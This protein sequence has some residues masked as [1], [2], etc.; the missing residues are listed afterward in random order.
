MPD[1]IETL[2]YLG[3]FLGAA[4]E[5]EVSYV[6]I[7]QA[8]RQ[9]YLY[10]PYVIA[11]VFLGTVASD[12]GYFFL[13]RWQGKACLRRFPRLRGRMEQMDRLLKRR[14][15]LLL[16]SYRFMYGFRT[17]LPVLFGV[18]AIPASRF[19]AFS[20]LSITLWVSFFGLGGYFFA[21]WL[22]NILEKPSELSLW[23][24]SIPIAAGILAAIWLYY[25]RRAPASA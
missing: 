10:W 12:W 17:I 22:L 11:A 23:T 19:L 25:R 21:A 4:L 18:S 7:L 15:P 8:A 13:G 14:A 2:G 5:G 1:W 6:S 9:G 24:L 3:A 20:L 16:L